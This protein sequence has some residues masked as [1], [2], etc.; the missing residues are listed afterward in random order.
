MKRGVLTDIASM[1]VVSIDNINGVD[2]YNFDGVTGA[3]AVG[4]G[5]YDV[6]SIPVTHPLRIVLEDEQVS[7]TCTYSMTCTGGTNVLVDGNLHC[8]GAALRH[9]RRAEHCLDWQR[10]AA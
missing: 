6:F 3:M 9:A 7:D 8:A 5:Q 1:P 10:L 4:E 2:T